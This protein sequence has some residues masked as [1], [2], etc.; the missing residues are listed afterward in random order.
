MLDLITVILEE[1][2]IIYERVIA[3]IKRETAFSH[4]PNKIEVALGMR[5]SGKTFFLLQQMQKLLENESVPWKRC[6]YVNFEDD[7]LLPCSQSKFRE[8]LESFYKVY[9]ENH[10][11]ICYFFLDEVQNIED[12]SLVLRRFL[13]TKKIKIYISG[14]SAKLLSKEIATE[15]RGR[16]FPTEVWPFSFSEY[17]HAK[18][19]NFD[20]KLFGQ[21]NKDLL[22]QQLLNYINEGGFPEVVLVNDVEKKVQLLQEY[23]ELVVM[24][25]IIERYNIKNIQTIKYIIKTLLKNAGCSFSVNK[26]FNDFKSQNIPVT[27]GLLYDYLGYMEDAYLIFNIS[28]YDESI[29]KVNSNPKKSYAID[30][31]LI[32]A[33]T[34]SLNNNHG[35]LFEN[36]VYLDLKRQK[37]KIY[38][39]L[40]EQKYEVDFLVENLRGE[41]KLFQVVW[42]MTDKLTLERETRA[43]RAAEQELNIKGELITPEVYIKNYWNALC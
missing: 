25:D 4:F 34:F 27:R 31:G 11:H 20:T 36:L 38:Y 3:S 14:S 8:I 19:V 6:L 23:V 33:F 22:S 10:E 24:R 43:L 42:D 2:K 7:R 26:L 30:T 37:N 39:Y 40:T 28:L 16:S 12:W 29:R 41:R 13:D 35:H 15:L 9:P 21:K 1:Q 32:K 17:L 5:R 18:K